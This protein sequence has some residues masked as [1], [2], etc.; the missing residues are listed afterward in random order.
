MT[1]NPICKAPFIAIQYSSDGRISPCCWTKNFGPIYNK[2]TTIEQYWDH[3]K[4]KEFR[5]KMLS[6]EFPS[7]CK[8][9]KFSKETLGVNRISFYDEIYNV[10]HNKKKF[11]ED[12]LFA[13]IQLDLNF[14][15]IC[16]LKCRHCSSNNSSSW[17]KDDKKLNELGFFRLTNN[18][19]NNNNV[20][21]IHDERLFQTIE[22]ID[23]KGGE[24]MMQDEMFVLLKNL[25]KWNR[26]KDI[27]LSY[28][29][30]A[31]KSLGKLKDYWPHFKEV[32]CNVSIEATGNL[33]SYIRGGDHYTFED[34]HKNILE[35]AS[36]ESCHV[37]FANTV[38]IYN[39]FN[40]PYLI[41]YMSDAFDMFNTVS[42]N[43]GGKP[44]FKHEYKFN[45][46]VHSPEYLKID[47]MPKR[48]KDKIINH[49]EKFNYNSLENIK[50][51]LL[52]NE[53]DPNHTSLWNKFLKYTIML[54]KIRNTSLVNAEPEFTEYFE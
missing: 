52:V 6:N 8:T 37:H 43:T 27:K 41:N 13:P 46:I 49:Y 35:Y 33:F 53:F 48:L 38:M 29:T 40:L 1:N 36:I 11:T 19:V 31:T 24:P 15:N 51:S 16:N 3:Y 4:V 39:I 28:V 10:A 2:F 42:S 14:S 17:L 22:R 26:A 7:E 47:I 34:F 30:N 9:C 5:K 23:F 18:E 25:I 20:D 32:K 45:N 21:F 12:Q 44:S 54:D 50:Q